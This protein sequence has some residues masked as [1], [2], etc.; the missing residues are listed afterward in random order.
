MKLIN[1]IKYFCGE[2][3]VTT[4]IGDWNYSDKILDYDG[5][6]YVFV[7]HRYVRFVIQKRTSPRGKIETRTIREYD[8]RFVSKH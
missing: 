2:G 8:D 5:G 4:S 7:Y 6:W 1:W 3:W